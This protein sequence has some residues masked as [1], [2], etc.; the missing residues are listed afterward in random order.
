MDRAFIEKALHALKKYS[1]FSTDPSKLLGMISCVESLSDFASCA[2]TLNLFHKCVEAGDGFVE[3]D[4]P[5]IDTETVDILMKCDAHLKEKGQFFKTSI[6]F[7]LTFNAENVLE[8]VNLRMQEID[9]VYT[10]RSTDVKVELQT[11]VQVLRAAVDD[12]GDE[13][14]KADAT[15]MKNACTKVCVCVCFQLRISCLTIPCE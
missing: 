8:Y 10:S 7:F 2:R 5:L 6:E 11:A 13:S 15:Q 4:F 12:F 9:T 1:R 3:G 14:S